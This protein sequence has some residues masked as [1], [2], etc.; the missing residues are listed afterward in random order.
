M[1]RAIDT[2]VA[3]DVVNQIHAVLGCA[4]SRSANVGHTAWT[5]SRSPPDGWS[6]PVE[7]ARVLRLGVSRTLDET[8]S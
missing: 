8:R 1:T 4:E 5:P 6:L 2:V 7:A 3:D